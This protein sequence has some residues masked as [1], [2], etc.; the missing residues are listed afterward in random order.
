M[1]RRILVADDL[2]SINQGILITASKLGIPEV[3]QVQYC[4]DAY[5]RLKKADKDDKPFELLITDLSFKSDHRAQKYSTGEELLAVLHREMPEL[6][7][8]VYSIE[9][10]PAKVRSFFENYQINGYVCKSRKGQRE[11]AQAI[12]AVYNLQRYLSPQVSDALD[13]AGLDEITEYDIELLRLL[14]EGRSQQEI[15]QRFKEWEMSPSSL[16]SIEKRLNK[17][18]I[19][20]SANNVVHL[21]AIVKDLGLI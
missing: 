7:V 4:D 18:R 1:F 9:D 5:V 3:I 19:D 21:V 8:I 20:F 16:S 2:D 13:G 12:K 10:R 6:N 15:S 17:L 11:L 14:S